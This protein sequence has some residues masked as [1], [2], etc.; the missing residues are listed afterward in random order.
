VH[1]NC[2]HPAQLTE[3]DLLDLCTSGNPANNTVYQPQF[4]RAR[5]Q[6]MSVR[7]GRQIT[8]CEVVVRPFF[9]DDDIDAETDG[10][11]SRRWK[12]GGRVRIADLL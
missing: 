6:R 9:A 5:D 2:D 8:G 10:Y 7:E 1:A 3:A 12:S 11:H 4:W